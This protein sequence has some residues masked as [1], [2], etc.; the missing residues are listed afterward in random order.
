MRNDPTMKDCPTLNCHGVNFIVNHNEYICSICNVYLCWD[1]KKNH[2]GYT[3]EENKIYQ[4]R[5]KQ[6]IAGQV[7]DGD[8]DMMFQALV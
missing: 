6:K 3:C 2:R 7:D 1:C 5:F 4:E 8:E